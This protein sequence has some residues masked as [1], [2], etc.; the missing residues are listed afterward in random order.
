MDLFDNKQEIEKLKQQRK[1][2]EKA[3]ENPTV[4]D[5]FS[6]DFSRRFCWSNNALEG[7]TLS[8]DETIELIDYDEVKSGHKYKEY[9]D[10]KNA[11]FAISNMLIP[12]RKTTIDEKWIQKANGYIMGGSGKYRIEDVYVGSIAEAVYYP[13]TPEKIGEL[14]G[15]FA[16][17]VNIKEQ[18]VEDLFTEIARQHM[19]FERI[20]PFKDGN[21]RTGRMIINQQL[22][23]NGLPPISITPTGKYRQ[24][25]RRY[26]RHGDLS[27]MT[28]ILIKSEL[29]SF[30]RIY[31]LNAGYLL[32]REGRNVEVRAGTTRTWKINRNSEYDI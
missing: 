17:K 29:E 12:F 10:A 2:A 4:A 9:Q 19:V 11:Y 8:L 7:N 22:I 32:D 18:S 13:P 16:E 15:Q 23:N 25:F 6:M 21:G 30:E 20:H 5:A 14:M 26:D 27:Q 1:S 28:H 31:D 24:A 3:L